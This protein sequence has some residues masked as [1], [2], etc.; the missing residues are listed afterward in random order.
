MSFIK[1]VFSPNFLMSRSFFYGAIF[2]ILMSFTALVVPV[3]LI[4]LVI[5]AIIVVNLDYHL[6]KPKEERDSK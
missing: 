1:K 3:K 4:L 5:F 6:T 2:S